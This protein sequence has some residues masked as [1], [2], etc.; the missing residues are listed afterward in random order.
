VLTVS[1]IGGVQ[2][3]R[4][5]ETPAQGNLDRI[6]GVRWNSASA[7]DFSALKSVCQCAGMRWNALKFI[8]VRS[9]VMGM[10]EAAPWTID[11]RGYR[12]STVADPPHPVAF[13]ESVTPDD[14]WL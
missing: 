5:G 13:L 14:G 4:G 6:I 7:P 9:P 8:I 10:N 2:P 11:R 1:R 3:R 12:L